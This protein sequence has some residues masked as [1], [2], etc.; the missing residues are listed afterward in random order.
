ML[1][2]E[3]MA[4]EFDSKWQLSEVESFPIRMK[5]LWDDKTEILE[6]DSI[7]KAWAYERQKDAWDDVANE[8]DKEAIGL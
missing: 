5:I 7:P 2:N 3:D 6:F 8:I 1:I 4:N